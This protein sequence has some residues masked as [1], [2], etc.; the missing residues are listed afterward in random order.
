LLSVVI[1]T[2]N[3]VRGLEAT[4]GALRWQTRDDVEVVVVDGPSEDGTAE[5]LAARAGDLRA[6][7]C[8]D[9]NLAR[10]RNLGIDAAAGEFVAF[11][12][13]DAVPEPTWLEELLA[14][15][16]EPAVA[17]VGG[18]VL[19]HTGTRP[20]YRF[21]GCSRLGKQDFDIAPPFD[22]LTTPGADPFLYLTGG[23]MSFRRQALAEVGG[24]D[25]EIEYNYEDADLCLRLID[26]GHT[27]RSLDG[28]RVHHKMAPS[29]LRRVPSLST[30]PFFEIKNRA[31]F[32]VR[33]GAAARSLQEALDDL[34][35]HARHLRATAAEH[36]RAERLSAAE[37]EH[38]LERLDAGF[39]LGVRRGL[40]AAPQ[41]RPIAAREPAAF[42][43]YPVRRPEGRRLRVAFVSHEYPPRGT[44][45]IGRFTQDLASAMASE[46]HEVHVV[47]RDQ[48]PDRV[49]LEDGVWV[50]RHPE[51]ERFVPELDGHPAGAA[52]KHMAAVERAL[53]RIHEHAP[54][55][56]VSAPL[57]AGEALLCA[58]DPR[59][60]TVVT[61]MTPMRLVAAT[62]PAVAERAE[63]AWQIRLEDAVL[64]AAERL[65]GISRANMDALPHPGSTPV[66]VLPLG[67]TDRRG[68]F[69]PRRDA[70]DGW[71]EVLFAGRLEPRKGVD[72]LL[73][74]AI[75]LLRE[76][77]QLRL[78]LVGAD[79]GY[80]VEGGQRYGDRLRLDA[81]DVV[82][83]V[84]FEGEVS[85]EELFQAY[86][87]C[88]VFCAPSR[89]ESFGLVLLEAMSFARPVVASRTGGMT[90]IVIDGD[91]GVLVEPGDA[92]GLRDA[93]RILIG[94]PELRTRLGHAGRARFERE[95]AAPV[96]AR[97]TAAAYAAAAAP[98]AVVA[99]VAEARVREATTG[100]LS[101]V[102][103]LDS[104]AA[105]R[106]ATRLLA[107][108]AFPTD[109]EAAVRR[110][111]ANTDDAEFIRGLYDALLGRP[112]EPD[113]LQE[114]LAPLALGGSRL[115]VVRS[116][117]GSDEARARGVDPS[118]A[119]RLQGADPAGTVAA[120]RAT[121]T[122][123]DDRFV[124]ALP[125]AL[126]IAAD[127]P[128]LRAAVRDVLAEG[129]RPAL[130]HALAHGDVANHVNAPTRAA[131]L[132][133]ELLTRTE[134]ETALR[135]LAAL[136]DEAFVDG[137]YRLLLG[138]PADSTGLED[139][140]AAL[141]SGALRL[142]L[143]RAVATSGEA[144]ARGIEPSWLEG[145]DQRVSDLGRPGRLAR[146][147]RALRRGDAGGDRPARPAESSI[148][149]RDLIRANAAY[150]DARLTE[151]EATLQRHREARDAADELWRD[152]LHAELE[153]LRRARSE[154]LLTPQVFGPED[155]LSI[156]PTAKVNDALFNTVSG[157]VTVGD[158]AF[159]GHGVAVLTGTHD[160]DVVGPARQEAIPDA[161]RDVE[162]G[163]GA[164]I[165]SRATVLGPCQIGANAVVAAG[166]VVTGDVP[167]GAVFAGVPARC[168]R[169]VHGG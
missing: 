65:H 118:L 52:I 64:A 36:R 117:A 83:R 18:I 9:R 22:A 163:E 133:A 48:P 130:E 137:L 110:V 21:I 103:E 132:A 164:W 153:E 167:A 35:A 124:E 136:N 88:D 146:A 28:A 17:G 123:D 19:D 160:V 24:F 104:E 105:A 33:H 10:S 53:S 63:T 154:T 82:E 87:D 4:L 144:Q 162:I 165:A 98:R 46:G 145:L 131:L 140:A 85:D 158:H 76:H 142:D 141:R 58:S 15:Y 43:R 122:L 45:G 127:A 129:R 112:P 159:F 39:E 84:V 109:H 1:S 107:P 71:I 16:D 97:R 99:E 161:G 75:P 135:R 32:A 11:I 6:V 62:Q 72:V 115:D 116:I 126:G 5:L 147:R 69:P 55:D 157:R 54:L 29:H 113:G 151:L 20:Q 138:R 44:G 139:R 143:V 94:D 12:D 7:R 66:D 26:A 86:A 96:I 40:E 119:E 74:A 78:R 91:T 108:A 14:G 148:D 114:K 77:A 50:H 3:R 34:S 128:A 90:E 49:D 30:D 31:Y 61:C 102:A 93:L 149:F 81:P 73:E 57:W 42:C 80:A 67:A 70:P 51:G 27:L 41:G 156:A 68:E 47:T 152:Q 13:D 89:Y 155:R 120:V 95:F 59:W 168:V 150:L 23:N 100:V 125:H 38:W 25:E 166:A 106:A 79:T 92:E 121:W 56:V 8:P 37:H 111:A 60:T 134:I 2:Y 169:T 101:D